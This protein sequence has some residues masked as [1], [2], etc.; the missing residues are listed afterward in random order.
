MPV[1]WNPKRER[2]DIDATPGAGKNHHNIV[3]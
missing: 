1:N 2:R 3:K